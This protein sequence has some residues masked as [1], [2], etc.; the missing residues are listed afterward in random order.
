MHHANVFVDNLGDLPPAVDSELRR[1]LGVTSLEDH[2]INSADEPHCSDVAE[3][4]R[5]DSQ[6]NAREC[7]LEGDWKASLFGLLRTL[8]E[9]QAAG[10]L[11]VHMSEKLWNPTLKPMGSSPDDPLGRR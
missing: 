10:G 7:S 11:K 8:S 1:I 5:S 4:Y 2:V 9:H 3:R 6:R